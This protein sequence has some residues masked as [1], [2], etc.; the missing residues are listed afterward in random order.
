MQL[1]P[2]LRSF[3]A[4]CLVALAL[5]LLAQN[6]PIKILLG[7]P[8]GGSVDITARVLADK[9][10]DTLGVPVLVEN[11]AGAGGRI[12]AQAVKDAAPDG[13]TLM[14]APFAVMV[15]QPMVFKSIKYDTGKDFTA[16][17][18]VVSFP[19]ALAAGPATP[20]KNMRELVDWLRANP[21]KANYGSPA[22]GSMPHFLGELLAKNANLTLTHVP[23][24][25]GAPMVQ[26]LLGG[27]IS[28]A[29]DTPAEFAE[30]YRAGKLRLLAVSSANARPSFPRCQPFR[31]RALRSM[32][33]PG[34]P[35]LG[36]PPWRPL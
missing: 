21:D 23:F 4:A 17:G 15:V 26:N 33:A 18:S 11:R 22:A 28:I 34:L 1:K 7:F 31:S 10:K 16:L 29:F 13:N 12:A 25:G 32:P 6:Q 36:Q 14:L 20:A 35:C 24:Q 27:Q 19:L 2:A 30:Q 5:P 3:A 9:M 8:A